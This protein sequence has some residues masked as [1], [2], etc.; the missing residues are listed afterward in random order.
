MGRAWIV[1]CTRFSSG[2][3]S[4]STAVI[5]ADTQAASWT[6][7]VRT[8][9][10]RD[11]VQVGEPGGLSQRRWKKDQQRDGGEVGDTAAGSRHERGVSGRKG[12]AFPGGWLA[13]HALVQFRRLVWWL[14]SLDVVVRGV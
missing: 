3:R 1:R 12:P 5:L 6:L 8:V 11:L 10:N 7:G 2:R 13:S 9:L 4:G 14:I